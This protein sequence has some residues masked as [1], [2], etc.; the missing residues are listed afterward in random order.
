[1]KKDSCQQH[2][3]FKEQLAAGERK[4]GEEEVKG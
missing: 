4:R 2:V 3:Y 1:M